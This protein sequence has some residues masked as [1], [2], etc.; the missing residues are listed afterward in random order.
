VTDDD[1]GIAAAL[2]VAL[3]AALISREDAVRVVDREIEQRPSSDHW[4]IAASLATSTQ[5]LLRVLHDRA[6]GHSL[7][8]EVWPL[9]AAMEAALASGTDPLE[10]ALQI[11]KVY[12]YGS[13]PA[14]LDQVLYDV[15]EE[16]TCAHA[17]DGVPQ[18]LRV[19]N[20]LHA[21]FRADRGHRPWEDLMDRV[22]A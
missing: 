5:D 15:Y 13:W 6:S 4:L 17:H 19:A 10:V 12:P 16:A 2:V 11:Q 8:N 20:A 21:L 22:L 3:E 7:L 18:P 1:Q 9:L 14:H